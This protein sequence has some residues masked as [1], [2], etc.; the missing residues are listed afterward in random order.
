[1]TKGTQNAAQRVVDGV[2]YLTEAVSS[3]SAKP[4][5]IV[6]RWV[7]DQIAPTY[8]VPNFKIT[9]SYPHNLLNH[10]FFCCPPNSSKSFS[11]F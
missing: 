5:K 11:S 3:I 7:A 6:S 9:V 4:T 2:T 1:M 10:V 8:W